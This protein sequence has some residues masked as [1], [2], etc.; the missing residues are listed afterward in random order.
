MTDERV[1]LTYILETITN[2][3]ELTLQ[4]KVELEE[5]KHNRA[6]VLYYLY[7]LAEAT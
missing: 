1:Y 4:G 3:Q 7:T 2:I 5:A 6:A